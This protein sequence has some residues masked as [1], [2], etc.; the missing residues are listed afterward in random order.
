MKPV[1][2][3]IVSKDNSSPSA[4]EQIKLTKY[5]KVELTPLAKKLIV[6]AEEEKSVLLYGDYAS[7][8]Y[9][10]M[11][12][13]HQEMNDKNPLFKY[14]GKENM[15]EDFN[16]DEYLAT[17]MRK[18]IENRK[19]KKIYELFRDFKRT[20]NTYLH[21]DCQNDDGETV[22]KKL[23]GVENFT[24][25]EVLERIS[26]MMKHNENWETFY[27]DIVDYKGHLREKRSSTNYFCEPYSL[28]TSYCRRRLL[29]RE[30]TLF[31]ENLICEQDNPKDKASYERLAAQIKKDKYEGEDEGV[32][33][34]SLSGWLVVCAYDFTTFPQR[35]LDQFVM[36]PLDDSEAKQQNK[37]INKEGVVVGPDEKK[38]VVCFPVPP[39]TKWTDVEIT[40]IDNDHVNIKVKDVIKSG[41]HY[42]QVG[43]K[44]ET[45]PKKI[46]LWD[47]LRVFALKNGLITP[48]H[49]DTGKL[50]KR[51]GTDDVKRLRKKLQICFGISDNPIP[52]Y[53]K[54]KY[55]KKEDG[56]KEFIKGEG[57][58]T[59]FA[60][61][62]DSGLI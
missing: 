18:A 35:F 25:N 14:V 41:V 6:F 32:W 51:V 29:A 61:K 16:P 5:G 39:D 11:N 30:G 60:I 9:V 62:D 34:I 40:F 7:D 31:V 21:I 2:P 8:L 50:I 55:T 47:T 23:T 13:F 1:K 44:H 57:Y 38:E 33:S 17:E 26:S 48:E 42:S 53:D 19:H 36:V 54:G 15:P 12:R 22:L 49:S 24:Q 45:A 4:K 58:K 28:S 46:Q 37:E 27:A 59:S 3:K 10:F 56:D 43:F 52:P 20:E